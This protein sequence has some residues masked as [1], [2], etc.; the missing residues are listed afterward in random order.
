MGLSDHFFDRYDEQNARCKCKQDHFDPFW[1]ASHRP[2]TNRRT[3]QNGNVEAARQKCLLVRGTPR[4]SKV[5]IVANPLRA[6]PGCNFR[7]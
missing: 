2:I 5:T 4:F 1:L 6:R 7:A 3:E